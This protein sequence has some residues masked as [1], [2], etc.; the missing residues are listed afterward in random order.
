MTAKL[1]ENHPG[2]MEHMDG[3]KDHYYVKQEGDFIISICGATKTDKD[4]MELQS[5]SGSTNKCKKCLNLVEKI[6][7]GEV[8][9]VKTKGIFI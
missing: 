3:G 1:K 4:G 7:K 9:H 5:E 2:W 6:Q 8:V